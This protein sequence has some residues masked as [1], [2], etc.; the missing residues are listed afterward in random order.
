MASNEKRYET[1]DDDFLTPSG[2]AETIDKAMVFLYRFLNRVSILGA[3][4]NVAVMLWI[5]VFFFY[6]SRRSELRKYRLF[7]IYMLAALLICFV[8]PAYYE[9]VRYGFPI[10]MT[11]PFVCVF[12]LLCKKTG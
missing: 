6:F 8:S 11:T 10:L 5:Y 4:E 1:P 7:G 12:T 2:T 3:L 9:H